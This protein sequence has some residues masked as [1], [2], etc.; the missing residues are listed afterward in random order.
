MSASYFNTA[1]GF[2]VDVNPLESNG[3]GNQSTPRQIVDVEVLDSAFITPTDAFIVNDDVSSRMVQGFSF[4]VVDGPYAGP[5]TVDAGAFA[6]GATVCQVVDGRTHIPVSGLT[7]T[8]DTLTFYPAL[9]TVDISPISFVPSGHYVTW[10][11][12]GDVTSN[13]HSTLSG[14]LQT[15]VITNRGSGYVDGVHTNI[16]M[17]STT[18]VGTGAVATITI[19]GGYVTNVNIG[20]TAGGVGY[21][22]GDTLTIGSSGA[23]GGGVGFVFRVGFEALFKHITYN[24]VVSTKKYTVFDVLLFT[25]TL[26]TYTKVVTTLYDSIVPVIGITP[27]STLVT[28]YQDMSG[29]GYVQYEVDPLAPA[30]SLMLVGKG[31][32]MF[33]NNT[34]W[35]NALQANMI[36]MMEHFASTVEPASPMDGQLWF[37]TNSYGPA[38]QLR[39]NSGWYGVVAEGLPV[40][41]NI[42][43]N[44]FK[45]AKVTNATTTFP[46]VASSTGWGNNDQEA[47]NLGTSDALYI[48][49]T[50][51]YDADP[52]ARSGTMTGS[53]YMQDNRIVF[54]YMSLNDGNG[55]GATAPDI[56]FNV[57]GVVAAQEHI[58]HIIDSDNSG[59]GSFVISKGSTSTSTDTKLLTV[60]LTGEVRS[61]VVGYTALVTTD[62]TLTNKKYVDDTT[63]SVTGDTMSGTLAMSGSANI[64]LDSGDIVLGTG[65]NTLSLLRNGAAASTIVFNTGSA[66]TTTGNNVI[67]LGTNM[68]TGLSNAV[69]PTDAV[70]Q[71]YADGRYVNVTGDTMTGALILNADPATALG[72]ATKQYV[73]MFVSG[74]IWLSP[75]R[76][77]SLFN[78]ALS[79]PPADDGYT[80]YH[81]SFVVAGTGTGAWAGFDGHLMQFNGSTWESILGRP[82]AIGDRFGVFMEP[83]NDDPMSTLPGG[84][85]VGQTGKIATVTGVSPYS[86]SFYTPAEPD[87]LTVV[88]TDAAG[89][90]Q[91]FH[92]GHSYTFRGT[93]GI[94]AYGTDYEWIEF[95]GP[96]TLID[97]DGLAYAGQ[98]LNVDGNLLSLYNLAT[99]GILARTATN[100]LTAR[101]ITGTAGNVVVSSGD[102]VS[103][104]PTIDLATVAQGTVG[105]AFVKVSVDGYGR[106][107][108]N[109]AVTAGDITT[110]LAYTPVNKA[111]D[112]MSGNLAMSGSKVTGL[113]AATA[114][115]D[116]VRYDEYIIH[117]HSGT[118]ASL[119]TEQVWTAQQIPMSGTLTDGATVNWNADVNGQIVKVTLAGTRT[120]AAPTNVNENACYVLRVHQDAAG[121]RG[122]VWDAAYKFPGGADPTLTPTANAVD[123]FTFIGGAANVLYCVGQAKGLS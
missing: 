89:A 20:V 13:F 80:T 5:Y 53:L 46:Y 50:G 74:I 90:A 35:G 92:M 113:A 91:S 77:S 118:Y 111:G 70:S 22:V 81:K 28:P 56:S 97:G 104:N 71:Q 115:G 11:L 65:N 102:G 73:D 66:T 12:D 30:T 62:N 31:A 84:G 8:Y 100:T 69:N 63:V 10:R 6:I 93:F 75:V 27:Q 101:T 9:P 54:D 37:D 42:N 108:S 21:T 76:D 26:H 88:G 43:M 1:G 58:T 78:D 18:G 112:A 72:A 4:D 33:N 59:V 49:K 57:S 32:P 79:A 19:S 16:P 109:T 47:M 119:S 2:I 39:Y 83:D 7:T 95:L 15:G 41:G 25:S 116:A 86:Y 123:I 96:Q 61:D 99:N 82:V 85:L 98:T 103:A 14:S 24:G 38:L 48:A 121:G 55:T 94:G 110:S 114:N 120:L 122:L 29:L 44:D 51:G 105:T 52:A 40:Q 68:I 23:V 67:N 45:I 17:V 36:H 64:T 87:A 117:N 107:T 60:L 34:T 3:T 106:V